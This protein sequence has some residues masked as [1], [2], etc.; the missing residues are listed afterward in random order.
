MQ[1]RSVSWCLVSIQMVRMKEH[2]IS[3]IFS[4]GNQEISNIIKRNQGL[5]ENKMFCFDIQ[6][7]PCDVQCPVDLTKVELE[8]QIRVESNLKLSTQTKQSKSLKQ[9]RLTRTRI[10]RK[11][12]ATEKNKIMTPMNFPGRPVVKA[13]RFQCRGCGLDPWSRN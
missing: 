7:F 10:Y 2:G 13:L 12:T 8:R 11:K 6:N 1:N 3:K 9:I 5:Q 4:L